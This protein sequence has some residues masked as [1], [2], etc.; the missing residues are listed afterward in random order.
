MGKRFGKFASFILSVLFFAF[1]SVGFLTACG[2]DPSRF[3]M[4]EDAYEKGLLTK[5][6]LQ[7]F[8]DSYDFDESEIG[9]GVLKSMKRDYAPVFNLDKGTKYSAKEIELLS[10]RG[11][12]RGIYVVQMKPM[13]VEY[14]QVISSIVVDGVTIKYTGPFPMAYQYDG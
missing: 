12:Y 5:E 2:A 10:Y 1:L 8:A 11:K 7:T 4:L 14:A 13:N 3:L 9:E 6:D